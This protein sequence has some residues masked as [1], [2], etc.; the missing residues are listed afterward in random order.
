MRREINPAQYVAST[1]DAEYSAT[2]G[3]RYLFADL[4]R[5]E[6]S[7]ETRVNIA[8]SPKV[9]FQLFAQPLLSAGDYLRYKQLA[10]PHSFD[11]DVFQES[12]PQWTGSRI[13]R[14]GGR[15]C[16]EGDTR[17]L[18]FN[19]DGATDYSFQERDF[20]I[21]S[22]RFNAVFLWEYRPGSTLYL[23]W[24]QSRRS[25][26]IEGL[27]ELRRDWAEL[28]AAPSDNRFIVKLNYWIG[29]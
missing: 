10:R 22:L 28:W 4:E 7:M 25:S 16:R 14:A 23:V 15:T 12:P 20:T 13:S 3:R 1:P 9:T 6:L 11:F 18:D 8:L 24:Q 21:R 26:E 27:L 2:F 5:R 17:Y 29:L 19:G